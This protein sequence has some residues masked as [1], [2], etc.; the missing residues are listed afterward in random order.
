MTLLA[1]PL[2]ESNELVRQRQIVKTP[3]CNK[4][5]CREAG[6]LLKAGTVSRTPR[7]AG[8][9]A[10]RDVHK[11]ARPVAASDVVGWQCLSHVSTE[12]HYSVCVEDLIRVEGKLVL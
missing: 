5:F 2:Q 7:V 8:L 4:A 12:H 6:T 9:G 10:G 1:L 3:V 11:R